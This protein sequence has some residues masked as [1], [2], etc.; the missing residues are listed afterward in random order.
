[1]DFSPK[2]V[3]FFLF[4]ILNG[5]SR[6]A[7]QSI[8]PFTL[9]NG[10]GSAPSMEWSMGESICIAN[11]SGP[12]LLLN[13][14]VLQP[15]SSVVTSI[16]DNNTAAF[17]NELSIGPIPTMNIVHL[18]ARFKQIGN[19]SLQ[20]LDVKSNLLQTQESGGMTSNID[21]EIALDA[22]PAGIFYIRVYFKPIY[23]TI[24]SGIYKIIKI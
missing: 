23:G 16:F 20:V 12:G 4:S 3:F 14:G 13:T 15:L 24:Q 21:M 10:G 11:F 8:T 5:F 17:S 7:A 9:N 18:R 1:M 2:L 6:L 22:Y 19:M